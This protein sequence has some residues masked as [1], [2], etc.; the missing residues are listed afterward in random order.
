MGKYYPSNYENRMRHHHGPP[1]PITSGIATKSVSQVPTLL[2]SASESPRV[3]DE[4]DAKRKLQQYQRDMIA[5]ATL[6]AR[7]VLG[8]GENSTLKL[9]GF[10]VP[11]LPAGAPATN[12]LSPRLRPLGSP[13]PVTPMDLEATDGSYLDKGRDPHAVENTTRDADCSRA[14]ASEERMRS[15]PGSYMASPAC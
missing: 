8:S 6:A 9:P 15:A 7:K 11:G 4:G 1:V 2:S 14:M 5:Q 13:G 10:P 3:R 12:P